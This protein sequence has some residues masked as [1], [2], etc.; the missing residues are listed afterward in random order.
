MPTL[1]IVSA[2]DGPVI[3]MNR[4]AVRR[5]SA[6]VMLEIVPGATYLFPEPGTLEHVAM[7]ASGWFAC[8]LQRTPPIDLPRRG[9]PGAQAP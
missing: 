9:K 7:L 2:L 1:L 4:N 5:M 6:E 3:Q 8:H